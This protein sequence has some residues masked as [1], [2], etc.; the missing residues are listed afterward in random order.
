MSNILKVMFTMTINI[1]IHRHPLAHPSGGGGYRAAVTRHAHTP[2]KRNFKKHI[3]R[4]HN[5]IKAFKRFTLHPQSA[6][7][8]S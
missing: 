7:D 4:R 5:D 8:I 6:T 1:S 3:L 2:S